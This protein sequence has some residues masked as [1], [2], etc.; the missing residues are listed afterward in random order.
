MK[1]IIK[2]VF[3]F[4]VF[5][6]A[7]KSQTV[8]MEE[9]KGVGVPG[10]YYC[11]TNGLFLPFEGTFLYTNG[12]KSLKVVLKK[13]PHSSMGDVYFEDLLVGEFEYKINNNIV[14]STLDKLNNVYTNGVKN[15]IFAH[16]I[17]RGGSRICPSCPITDIY[18]NGQLKDISAINNAEIFLKK[19]ISGGQEAIEMT[20]VWRIRG[21]NKDLPASFSPDASF[22]GG[23]YV[24]IKQ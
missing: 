15:S 12:N 3:V 23:V 4:L 8:N 24:L 16:G 7:C 19:I 18:I 1:K 21:I 17:L 2:I 10:K 11:D 5:T 22:P 14:A 20:I 13:F 9:Y 6:T